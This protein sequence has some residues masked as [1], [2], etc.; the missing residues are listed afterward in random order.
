MIK[1]VQD[2]AVCVGEQNLCARGQQSWHQHIH[3]EPVVVGAKY[4]ALV[5]SAKKIETKMY[6]SLLV[7]KIGV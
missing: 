2:N 7:C 3:G 1:P 5:S 4:Q 6:D